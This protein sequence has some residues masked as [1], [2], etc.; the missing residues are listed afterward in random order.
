M[1]GT[2]LGAYQVIAKLGEGGMGEVY[3]ARDTKLNRDVALKVLPEAFTADPDR[4]ARF[5]REAHVLASLNHPNIAAIYGV[6]ESDGVRAL[7]LPTITTPAMTQLGVILGTAAYMSP[8]QAKGRAAD[9]RSD[10]WAFGC[11]LYEMLTGKRAFDGEDSTEVIAAVV[12]GEPDWSA[13]PPAAPDHIRLLLRRCLEKDRGKRIADISTARFLL[14]E[15]FGSIAG[16]SQ[17]ASPPASTPRAR[18]RTA[19]LGL[20]VVALGIVTAAALWRKQPSADR[21]VT[22]FSFTMSDG[23]PHHPFWSRDGKELFYEPTI[24]QLHAIPVRTQPEFTF[25]TPVPLAAGGY[26]STNPIFSRNRDIDVDGNR[27]IT[28]AAT[29][30]TGEPRSPAE[31]CVVLNWFEE[32]K[33]RMPSQ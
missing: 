29:D 30:E 4:I 17:T 31:I 26:G 27:F 22:R 25:G 16:A 33:A 11:V 3:R 23:P 32:L 7:V 24:A 13:L 18:W 19:S 8:E 14:T 10:I 6:E 20:A 2:T 9:K 21:L 5:K 12:R 15:P 1:I 28:F